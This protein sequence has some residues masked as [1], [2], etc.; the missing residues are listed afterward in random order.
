MIYVNQRSSRV[1]HSV[2]K[3]ETIRII[4]R[5]SNLTGQKSD[6]FRKKK[7]KKYREQIQNKTAI[8]LPSEGILH[9]GLK[10]RKLNNFLICSVRTLYKESLS[11]G[12]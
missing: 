11:F 12:D 10:A 8:E 2:Y 6:K 5:S 3:S 4:I 7:K 1:K 9:Q